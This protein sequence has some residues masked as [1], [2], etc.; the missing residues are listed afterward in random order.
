VLKNLLKGLPEVN[1]LVGYAPEGIPLRSRLAVGWKASRMFSYVIL[2]YKGHY[3][4]L[5]YPTHPTTP[6]PDLIK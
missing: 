2:G 4:D 3:D 6:F 1:F 5:F